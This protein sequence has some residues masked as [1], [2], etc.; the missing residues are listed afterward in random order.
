[1][2][3]ATSDERSIPRAQPRHDR[4]D[5]HRRDPRPDG[6]GL[7]GR[8]PA[9]DRRRRH[10]PR[11]VHRGRRPQA[12]RRGPHR[13]R[14]R[15]QGDRRRPRRQQGRRRPSRSTPPRSSAPRPRPR[16]RSRPC[17]GRCSSRSSR[18]APASCKEG[19]TI[20]VSRTTSPYDV[21][22]AFSGLADRAERIDTDR[23]ADSH[24]HHRRPDQGHPGGVPGHP[25]RPVARSRRPSP[26]AT[27]RSTSCSEPRLGLRHAGRPRRG[28][29]LP[30]EEQR[31]PARAP[32]WP[33]ATRC[34]DCWSRRA[35]S[36]TS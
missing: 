32:W 25:A 5:Q 19:S 35:S 8:R 24:R 10:L 30:D 13:R 7:Q 15:R 6:R 1:M 29:R 36:P 33:G 31:H 26:A 11:R 18:R 16:S 12:Q 2:R 14:P 17:S 20:P 4:R 27:S 9:P 22:Q 21:V 28:H 34:T 23:L 3:G